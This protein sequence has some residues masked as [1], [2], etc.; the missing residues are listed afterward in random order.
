MYESDMVFQ[1]P[2]Y[3]ELPALR[4]HTKRQVYS[5]RYTVALTLVIGKQSYVIVVCCYTV[6]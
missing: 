5:F 3:G 1:N 2:T 4:R 6:A